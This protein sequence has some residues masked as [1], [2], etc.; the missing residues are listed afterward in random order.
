MAAASKD[1]VR[2][3]ATHGDVD[4]LRRIV[5]EEG[6]A[7]VRLDDDAG[8]LTTLH[9]AAAAGQHE[10]VAYLLSPSVGADARAARMNHFTPLHSAAMTG[11]AAICE[12][13][14]AAGAEVNVQTEPQGYTPLHSA[15]FGGHMEVIQVLIHH[16]ADR[17]MLNHRRER[18]ADTA[19]R[20]GKVAASHLLEGNHSVA[21]GE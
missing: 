18:A 5:S 9:H 19:R 11:H 17:A 3:A 12:A 14:L 10:V 15:A 7:A 8:D 20:Q 21:P 6:A 1:A 2:Y 13:L 16:G 4:A